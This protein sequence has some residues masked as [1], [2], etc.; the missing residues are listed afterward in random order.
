MKGKCKRSMALES[1]SGILLLFVTALAL[2]A[3]DSA[4]K[5]LYHSFLPLGVTAGSITIQKGLSL[6]FSQPA[7]AVS[8]DGEAFD[9]IWTRGVI[10]GH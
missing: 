5:E 9:H 6:T 7:P 8:N 4:L 1:T 2:L 3:E 10:F